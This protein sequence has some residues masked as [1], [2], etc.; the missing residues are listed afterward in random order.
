M[1]NDPDPIDVHVGMQIRT[2]RRF[3]SI[4]QEMLAAELGLTF[5]QVQKYERGANRVSASKLYRI[6]HA[7]QCPVSS[8]FDGLPPLDTT[9][10]NS[11][12]DLMKAAVQ[13]MLHD[14]YGLTMAEAFPAIARSK[15]RR[16]LASLAAAI[17]DEQAGPDD[18]VAPIASII[19]KNHLAGASQK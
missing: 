7:L 6:A 4:S 18:S 15:T 16:A 12:R 9:T 1:A 11:G 3:L 5:Q 8:F 14:P 10:I 19:T 13:R 17:T 2:R